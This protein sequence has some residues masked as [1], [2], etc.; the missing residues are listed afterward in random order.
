MSKLQYKRA[1]S[2]VEF[3][4]ISC[5]IF[6]LVGTFT[7]YANRVLTGAKEVALKHELAAFRLNIRLY[8]IL[9]KD[10]PYKIADFYEIKNIRFDKEGNLF[11]PFGNKYIYNSTTNE[12][13]SN[14]PGYENW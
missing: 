4:I 14:T 9:G 6:V 2:V 11:D 5:V 10:I 12:I 7:I 8:K 1:F 13:K 3:L